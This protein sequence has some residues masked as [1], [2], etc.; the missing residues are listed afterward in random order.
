MSGRVFVA[1]L[2]LSGERGR[3]GVGGGG[4]AKLCERLLVTRLEL[5]A[6]SLAAFNAA[7]LANFALDLDFAAAAAATTAASFGLAPDSVAPAAVA[8]PPVGDAAAAAAAADV[9]STEGDAPPVGDAAAAD[10]ESTDGDAVSED[11]GRDS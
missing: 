2:E 7:F 1:D 4:E 3:G 11:A 6:N 8:A 5:S 9:E 10:V